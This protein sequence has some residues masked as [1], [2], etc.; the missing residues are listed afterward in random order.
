MNDLVKKTLEKIKQD[1]LV[2]ESRWNFLIQKFSKWFLVGLFI[3]L[4]AGTISVIYYLILQLDWD[5]H[6]AMQ[7]NFILYM[8]AILPYFW[9]IIL[10]LVVGATFLSIR[11]TEHGYRFSRLKMG[12]AVGLSLVFL[13]LFFYFLGL[14]NRINNI[15]IKNVP[16]AMHHT[17]TKEIQWMQPEKGLLAG[18]IIQLEKNEFQLK[19]LKGSDWTVYFNQ[20]TSVRPAVNFSEGEMVKIIGTQE[21]K[22]LFKAKEIRP[23]EGRG[24]MGEQGMRRG[25]GQR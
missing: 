6:Q 19:D 15:V 1:H 23:W 9:V 14:S 10:G 24:M 12:G 8:L 17:V 13:G 7:R 2:P 25:Q 5:L 22:S 20:E 16:Y 18:K 21:V 4:G 3:V 11:K